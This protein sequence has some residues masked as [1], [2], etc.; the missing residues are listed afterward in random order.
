MANQF[1]AWMSAGV[2]AAG[3]SAAAVAGAGD[4]MHAAVA[5]L[6]VGDRAALLASAQA[7][8]FEGSALPDRFVFNCV[9]TTLIFAGEAASP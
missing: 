5:K 2:V 6:F 4:P 8:G 7:A 1:L 9:G 3:V